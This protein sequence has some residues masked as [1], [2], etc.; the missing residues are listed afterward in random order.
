M[1]NGDNRGDNQLPSSQEQLY[2]EHHEIAYKAALDCVVLLQNNDNILPLASKQHQSSSGTKVTLIGDFC[3]FPRYQGMGSS[4]VNSTKEDTVL[5]H[6]GQHTDQYVFSRGYYNSDDESDR[7]DNSHKQ[8]KL[9]IEQAVNDSKDAEAIIIVA[10][11]P[12]S[13]ESEGFD[14]EHISLPTQ[15][16]ELIQEVCKANSN[17]IVV[18]YNGGPVTMPWKDK[19]KGIVECYLPGQAGA[20]ALVEILFGM[21]SPSGKLAESFPLSLND[22]PSNRYFPGSSHTVEYRE[23]LNVGYRYYDTARV[24]V[25]FPFGHGI[26]YTTFAYENC[27]CRVIGQQ[28]EE[29][30]GT[31]PLVQVECTVVNNGSKPGSEIIQLYVHHNNTSTQ[32]R[33]YHP[34]QQLQDFAKTEVLG[35]GQTEQVTF[36]LTADAFS[37]FDTGTLKFVMEEGA[38][39]EIRLGSSSRDIRWTGTIES[40]DIAGNST[41]SS[42][43]I[44]DPSNDAT[45]CHPPLK[46]KGSL[47]SPLVVDD[48]TFHDMLG[49]SPSELMHLSAQSLLQQ[50]VPGRASPQVESVQG[51]DPNLQVLPHD[52]HV[53]HP[54]SFLSEVEKNGYLGKLFVTIIMKAAETQLEDPND[55]NQRKVVQ[56]VVMNTP[57]RCIATF[58]QG[59]MSF[60]AL[61]LWI[62]LFN[63]HYRTFIY[64]FFSSFS[65]K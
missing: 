38:T 39:Y 3:Q 58:S 19:V 47:A 17:V 20:R 41:N 56:E 13:H 46:D 49:T 27:T 34:D 11:V 15:H 9:L 44:V 51:M 18:L 65:R 28:Q 36:L 25:L 48:A 1:Q 21:A 45:T 23:G 55:M 62:S 31:L 8:R 7:A 53:I 22:V 24:P 32:N 6:I 29:K 12:E 50:H 40:A 54:N 16:N 30:C 42:V 60:G 4:K 35:P 26:S 59:N 52:I 64:G 43:N 33:V 2:S 61:D 14:R 63:G 57:L 10:G 37:F 5:E